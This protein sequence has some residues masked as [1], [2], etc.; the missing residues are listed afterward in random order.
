MKIAF[1]ILL[2]LPFL[3]FYFVRK[4]VWPACAEEQMT[5]GGTDFHVQVLRLRSATEAKKT[6][7]I[8]PPTGGTNILDRS[9]ARLLCAQGVDVYVLGRWTGDDEKNIDLGVH[10]RFYA[11]SQRAIQAVLARVDTPFIGLLGTSVGAIFSAIAASGEEKVD[12]VFVIT[13]GA[14]IASV[15]VQSDQGVMVE[16]KKKRFAIH[17]FRSDEEYYQAL[18]KEIHLDP[19]KLPQGFKTKDLGMVV[20]SGDTKVPAAA[21]Q[22]LQSLWQPRTVYAFS[23]NHLG[24][25]LKAWFWHRGDIVRFF[26]ESAVRKGK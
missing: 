22:A 7:L 17:G 24:T 8:L 12:A 19:L 21:Q 6:V 26:L 1:F 25:I 2:L 4:S 20:S 10:Q 11:R 14:P 3:S 18:D 15:I 16:A 23:D 5:F 13:G 9:Y